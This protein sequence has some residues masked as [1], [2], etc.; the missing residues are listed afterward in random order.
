MLV[1][2]WSNDI[3]IED[4]WGLGTRL[5]KHYFELHLQLFIKSA[6]SVSFS[7]WT[8]AQRVAGTDISKT[9]IFYCRL[10]MTQGQSAIFHT[11]PHNIAAILH[12]SFPYP[13][14]HILIPIVHFQD[15]PGSGNGAT[16]S[17]SSLILSL[18]I[19]LVPP[20]SVTKHIV[21]VIKYIKWL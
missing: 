1:S 13:H 8:P 11:L 21:T 17:T 15:S 14:S 6:P 4:G 5:A 7:P 3:G 9:M 20:S 18:W 16:I 12:T 10:T 19:Y 2:L